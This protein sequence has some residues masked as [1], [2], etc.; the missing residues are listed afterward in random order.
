M[1][2]CPPQAFFTEEYTRDHP[3]DQEKLSRLKD[4]IAWQVKHSWTGAGSPR[5]GP[6][7][8]LLPSPLPASLR[9]TWP[10]VTS[11]P[12]PW[13]SALLLNP[14]LPGLGLGAL[15]PGVPHRC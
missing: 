10:S 15:H 12:V 4:L 14:Y 9:L 13:L 6:A 5:L 8:S 7:L 3:E 11:C 2:A 1:L